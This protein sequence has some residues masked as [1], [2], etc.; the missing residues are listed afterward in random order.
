MRH[1]EEESDEDSD[2]GSGS[3]MKGSQ[4]N[5]SVV[6]SRAPSTTS[7][8]TRAASD[9]TILAAKADEEHFHIDDR[10][11]LSDCTKYKRE[12]MEELNAYTKQKQALRS[13]NVQNENESL[14]SIALI[15]VQVL[16]LA[17]RFDILESS[18]NNQNNRLNY[19][20]NAVRRMESMNMMQTV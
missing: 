20:V 11:E 4:R 1:L 15:K 7:E 19:L 9:F 13:L 8:P 5:N 3:W 14:Q 10:V 18:Q 17:D 12:M 16:D 2:G 6:P